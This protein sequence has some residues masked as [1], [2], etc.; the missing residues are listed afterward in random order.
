MSQHIISTTQVFVIICE[1]SSLEA[2]SWCRTPRQYL[3]IS[4]HRYSLSLAMTAYKG[5]RGPR[6]GVSSFLPSGIVLQ[7]TCSHEHEK[8]HVLTLVYLYQNARK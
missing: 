5:S 6:L 7:E 1:A 4:S 8:R 2:S 3:V